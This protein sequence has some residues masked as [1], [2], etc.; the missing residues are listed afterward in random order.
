MTGKKAKTVTV[1]TIPTCCVDTCG[2]LDYGLVYTVYHVCSQCTCIWR[3]EVV[4]HFE[5]TFGHLCS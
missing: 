5:A 3:L 4:L 1:R 2:T